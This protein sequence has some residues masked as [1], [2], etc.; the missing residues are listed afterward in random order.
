[1][2]A[3]TAG[4]E[5]FATRAGFIL[6][7]AG[8]AVG[9]GNMWRFSYQASEGGGAAFVL[10]YVAMTLL[11]GIPLMLAEF[12]IGRRGQ[13]API[14][15]LRKLAGRG[16][17]RLG[18]VFV[19]AGLLILAYYSVIAGW[20]VRYAIEATLHGFDRSAAEHFG[21]VAAGGDADRTIGRPTVRSRAIR[22]GRR[23]VPD[24]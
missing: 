5:A 6:A 2:T 13:R 9:L 15:S 24:R 8:S 17:G 7:A 21:E 12:G 23:P 1:M 22:A 3:P 10:L 4:R 19:G 20:T 18:Y 14:G 16:W 11:L